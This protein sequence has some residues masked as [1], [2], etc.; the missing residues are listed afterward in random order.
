MAPKSSAE[1]QALAYCR[2]A[3]ELGLCKDDAFGRTYLYVAGNN[4][5]K[6]DN[7]SESKSETNNTN[8][9]DHAPPAQGKS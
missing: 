3:E 2:K 9:N 6:T 1:E 4:E 5:G 8:N 7:K